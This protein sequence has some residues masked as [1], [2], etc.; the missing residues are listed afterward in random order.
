VNVQSEDEVSFIP[1]Q[2]GRWAFLTA[3][4]HQMR[5]GDGEFFLC[6]Y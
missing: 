3:G 6:M 1:P 5:T 2:D 4:M